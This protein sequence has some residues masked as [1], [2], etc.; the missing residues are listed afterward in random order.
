MP[1]EMDKSDCV[2]AR[3]RE[4][5]EIRKSLEYK[6]KYRDELRKQ[7][8]HA[9]NEVHRLNTLILIQ[10]M[11]IENFISMAERCDTLDMEH[12]EYLRRFD[13]VKAQPRE[14]VSHTKW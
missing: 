10:D 2:P 4:A 11:V 5:D 1:I 7:K 6:H 3:M 12:D 8:T 9:E 14:G 13:D